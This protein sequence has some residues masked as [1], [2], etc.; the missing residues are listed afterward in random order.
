MGLSSSYE[1][2][3]RF[4]VGE[5]VAGEVVAG[6]VGAARVLYIPQFQRGYGILK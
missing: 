4:E 6:G 1:F 2:Y 3:K 5:V